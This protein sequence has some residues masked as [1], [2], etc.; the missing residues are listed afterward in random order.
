MSAT[1]G[2]PK[3]WVT[4]PTHWNSFSCWLSGQLHWLI[5][6]E[7]PNENPP[8]PFSVNAGIPDV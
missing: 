2:S 6:S 5:P 1:M 8:V 7:Y 4:L 3:M